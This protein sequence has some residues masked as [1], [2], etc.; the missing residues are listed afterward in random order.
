[1]NDIGRVH[2]PAAAETLSQVLDLVAAHRTTLFQH[3]QRLV[4]VGGK[5]LQPDLGLGIVRRLIDPEPV[6]TENEAL[7]RRLFVI[8]RQLHHIAVKGDHRL[9]LMRRYF[10][11][12]VDAALHF[13]RHGA[14][15]FLSR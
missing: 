6:R 4:R 9:V 12:D 5:Q 3:A 14:F 13:N 2:D 8:D 1:M 7:C 15:P 10:H 11:G